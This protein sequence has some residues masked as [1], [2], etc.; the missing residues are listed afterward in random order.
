MTRVS[1]AD[2]PPQRPR[3]SAALLATFLVP[4]RTPLEWLADAVRAAGLISF[5][6]AAIL[7]GALAGS[8]LALALLGVVA[9][10]F[11]GVRAAVDIA[12]SLTALV[13]A[14]CSVL[15][16]YRTL[17][18]IDIPIHFV[19]NGLLAL[20]VVVAGSRAGVVFDRR[21]LPLLVLTLSVGLALAA[22]WEMG[23]W[24]ASRFDDGVYVGYDDSILD[25]AMGGAGAGIAAFAVSAG[26]RDG[27]WRGAHEADDAV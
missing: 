24:V 16:L 3:G 12:V 5:I 17:T 8:V 6:V 1:G 4:P 9:P 14:W 27:R 10:R 22:V 26:L 20:L 25:M 19:L 18:W 11:L 15:D 2:G 7:W 13:A 21:G 23:E